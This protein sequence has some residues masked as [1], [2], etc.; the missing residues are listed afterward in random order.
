[1]YY[2]A[3]IVDANESGFNELQLPAAELLRLGGST[4]KLV[5]QILPAECKQLF[6]EW[7]ANPNRTVY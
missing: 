6:A 4:L 3:T 2:G 1:V 7:L 5:P